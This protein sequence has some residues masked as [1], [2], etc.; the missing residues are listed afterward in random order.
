MIMKRTKVNVAGAMLASAVAI[1]F[2]ASPSYAQGSSSSGQKGRVMCVG[3]NACKGQSACKTA[4]SPGPG[5]NSCKGQGF[6]FTKTAKECT[7]QG[8]EPK[9]GKM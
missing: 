9:T 4:M 7:K 8:G 5:K 1:S 6:V 2:L 3:A